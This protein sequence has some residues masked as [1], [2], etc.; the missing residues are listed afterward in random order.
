MPRQPKP[1][2]IRC[3]RTNAMADAVPEVS[4][5]P[6]AAPAAV[7]APAPP[8]MVDIS[9][10][11]A[12]NDEAIR[13]VQVNSAGTGADVYAAV[14]T[15][16]NLDGRRGRR[17]ALVLPSRPVLEHPTDNAGVAFILAK[18]KVLADEDAL[19]GVVAG[20]WIFGSTSWCYGGFAGKS[21]ASGE[22]DVPRGAL[23]FCANQCA[24]RRCSSGVGTDGRGCD[25]PDPGRLHA[26]PHAPGSRWQVD[27]D[28]LRLFFYLTS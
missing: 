27:P 28:L 23:D 6:S 21:D 5:A 19:T 3:R 18:E 20:S 2:P 13:V 11:G 4:A 7:A 24:I 12:A 15:V 10:I 26:S 14:R 1:F 25:V 17:L 16:F 9:I 8:N 22:V